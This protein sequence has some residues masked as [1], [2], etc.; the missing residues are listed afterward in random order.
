MKQIVNT[1]I[2]IA[3]MSFATSCVEDIQTNIVNDT[4]A[5]VEFI[6]EDFMP[7][8]ATKAAFE[9]STMKFQ[10]SADDIIGIFPETGWQTQFNMESGAGSNTAVFDGGSWGLKS[11]SKY[12]AYYPFSKE[13]FESM[14]M[15]EKV[16][17]SYDGQTACFADANGIVNLS[18]YDFMASGVSTVE[19]GN[20]NFTFKHLGALCRISFE[21]PTTATYSKIIISADNEV[22]PLNGYFDATDEDA[23]GVLKLE[24][25]STLKNHMELSF[26]SSMQLFA[27]GDKVE[28]YF[29]M[30]PVDLSDMTLKMKLVNTA[31]DF[32]ETTLTG[33]EILAGKSYSWVA[34]FDTY[35]PPI[36]METANCYVISTVGSYSFPTVKG[37]SVYYVGSVASAEVLWE[38][39]GTDVAP[40]VGDLISKVSYSENMITFS[41]SDTFKEGNALIAAKDSDGNILW[42]WHIWLTD[43]PA[44]QWY[45][46]NAGVMMDRNLGATSATPGD[47]G[48]LGLLYQWGRKDPFLGSSDISGNTKAKST[49]SSWPRTSS[50]S[51]DGTISY[52]TA[53]PTTFIEMNNNNY[54]WWYSSDSSTDDTR[55]TSTKTMYDPCPVGY[56]VPDGGPTGVWAT[57]FGTSSSFNENVYDATNEGFNFGRSET[58]KYLAEESTCWYPAAGYLDNSNGYLLST[59]D[60]G[61]YWSCS[62]NGKFAFGLGFG[63]NGG[64]FQSSGST[65]ASGRSVRCLRE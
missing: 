13:N 23:D 47:V 58:N 32:Y 33:Y 64:V 28:L 3:L 63:D 31:Y 27:S 59:G 8:D 19:N 60:S 35:E 51:S 37:N 41:T 12:Y 44:D 4:V 52:A 61:Y 14:D 57:A 21:A 38:S 11:A 53:N 39:F 56:R 40:N 16:P 50:S 6:I 49:L 9:V 20:V 17:Y 10:W 45:S 1:F 25:N 54:D 48:A 42:S 29:L 2:I 65:R 26:P 55:W 43:K 36:G 18:K 62:P 15:R 24:S 5:K 46:N 7:A 22:F 34:E 30:P